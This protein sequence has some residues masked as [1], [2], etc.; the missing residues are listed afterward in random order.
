MTV[1]ISDGFDYGTLPYNVVDMNGTPVISGGLG[2]VS[3]TGPYCLSING[4]SEW[5]RYAI[6]GTPDNI[7]IG[8]W[9]EFYTYAHASFNGSCI[10]IRAHLTT[11]EYIDI[12]YNGT[13]HAFDAYV[14]GNLVDSGTNGMVNDGYW[15]NLQIYIYVDNA[16]T[17]DTIHEGVADIS[18]AGDTLPVGAAAAIDYVYIWGAL[19]L[20]W[21]IDDIV[22][23]TGGQLGDRRVEYLTTTADT[24][25][26]DWSPSTGL[27][28][29]AM[30]DEAPASDTDYTY[31]T[32]NTDEIEMDLEDWDDTDKTPVFVSALA[33][34]RESAA[35]G[36]QLHVGVDSGG[37]DDTTLHTMTSAWQY[38]RHY[39]PQDPDAGPGAW[40]DAAI[41]ALLLRYEA[42]I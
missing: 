16:G 32:T 34:A 19:T 22:I 42:V 6:P 23:G 40:T 14:D 4:T 33:R 15:Y 39:M 5:A 18:Y 7:A 10:W 29:Y 36:E 28:N 37:T 38:Y 41:D 20:T 24:G 25:V 21:Y 35:T 30:I 9:L 3:H 8:C 17:I 12:R 2:G 13:T 26:N 1:A 27:D 31:A 11:G